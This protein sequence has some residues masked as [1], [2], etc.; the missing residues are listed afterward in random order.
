MP[1][2]KETK[3]KDIKLED[4]LKRL[5]EIVKLLEQNECEL[6]ESLKY[7][8]EGVMLTRACHSKL[9]EAEK[10]IEILTKVNV[11]GVETESLS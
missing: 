1:N 10:R 8:E 7:F 3:A 5:S 2:T 9:A 11:D 6:D 4:A